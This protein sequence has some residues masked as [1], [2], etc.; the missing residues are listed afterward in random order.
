M[1]PRT[2]SSH[3]VLITLCYSLVSTLLQ[4]RIGKGKRKEKQK[5]D[6]P[7]PHALSINS[8]QSSW[9]QCSE[10]MGLTFQQPPSQTHKSFRCFWIWAHAFRSSSC[11]CLATRK[12]CCTRR[13]RWTF[14]AKWCST[15]NKHRQEPPNQPAKLHGVNKTKQVG[16]RFQARKEDSSWQGNIM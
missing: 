6:Q 16:G 14:V 9:F 12:S 1:C 5:A 4:Q 2:M 7:E 15:R 10:Q 8:N 11:S 13:L 3:P